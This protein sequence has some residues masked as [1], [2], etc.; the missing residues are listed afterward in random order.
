MRAREGKI[1]GKFSFLPSTLSRKSSFRNKNDAIVKNHN[2]NKCLCLGR[3]QQVV[4]LMYTGL[5]SVRCLTLLR[6]ILFVVCK[7]RD[8]K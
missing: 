1:K 7:A 5:Q 3:R 8:E 2:N 4:D 6:F